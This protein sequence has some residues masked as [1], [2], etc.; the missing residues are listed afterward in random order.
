VSGRPSFS[1]ITGPRFASLQTWPNR[2][3]A[4]VALI[5]MPAS[6]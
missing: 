5:L 4:S 1:T 2:F 6:W 3:F